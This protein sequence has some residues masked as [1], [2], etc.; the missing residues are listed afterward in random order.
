M[1]HQIKILTLPQKHLGVLGFEIST[2]NRNLEH[3]HLPLL[4]PVSSPDS[5][6]PYSMIALQDPTHHQFLQQTL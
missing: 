6:L 2:E 1:A 3:E 4:R 5:F